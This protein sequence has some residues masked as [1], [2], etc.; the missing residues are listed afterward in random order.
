M[1]IPT[2]VGT[3]KFLLMEPFR[4]IRLIAPFNVPVLPR[5]SGFDP[6]MPQTYVGDRLFE[7]CA[8]FRMR[9][10]R[11][12]T[13]QCIICDHQMRRGQSSNRPSQHP[14]N[15]PTGGRWVDFR[16]LHPGPQM[17]QT[18]LVLPSGAPANRW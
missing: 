12:R 9:G 6:P 2:M 11:H 7:G 1:H 3:G 10:I 18:R 13:D 8:S 15:P 17:N 5:Q 4:M 16:V 14:G